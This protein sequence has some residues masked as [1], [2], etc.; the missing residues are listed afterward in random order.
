MNKSTMKRA[1]LLIVV[2]F[3]L[4]FCNAQARLVF[5]STGTGLGQHPWVVFDNNPLTLSS[6]VYLVIDNQATNAIT[7]TGTATSDVPIIK[8]EGEQRMVR[9]AT[10][11]GAG[12]LGAH[13]VPFSTASGVAIPLTVNIT[14]AG[15]GGTN[16]S[17][18]FSTYNYQG[19]YPALLITDHWNNNL[20]RP[21]GVTH[22]NSAPSNVA[23]SQNAIDRFWLM[24]AGATGYNYGT[25]PKVS[26]DIA[27]DPADAAVN[28]APGN[29]PGLASVLVA[30]RFN[31]TSNLWYDIAPMGTLGTN[32]VT[33]AV[34]PSAGD[35]YRA[36]TLASS[37]TPLPIELV[38]WKGACNGRDVQLA[39]TTATEKDNDHFTVEK[40]SDAIQWEVIGTLPGAGNSSSMLSYAFVD[41][42]AHASAYYRLRQ[43]DF[44]GSS[45]LSAVITAGC[46]ATGATVLVNAWDSNGLLYLDVASGI[47]GVFDLALLDMEGRLLATRAAQAVGAGNTLL[48]L[49][50]RG[51][52]TGIYV[53]RLANGTGSMARRVHLN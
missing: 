9:W 50:T 28:G 2:S 27:F 37:I 26:I 51:I 32:V 10:R 49:D 19:L 16:P 34:P 30:Q 6:P 33:G 7:L 52:A 15:I 1:I 12:S 35:F 11:T 45:T 47:E 23:N 42:D 39:W 17:I 18:V 31:T 4:A 29:T 43:T 48:Q 3:S 5:N 14:T 25:K 38:D 13:T 8:S 41:K 53:V 22:M 20:Y 21:T 44:N 24:D 36:W 40:S 46:A